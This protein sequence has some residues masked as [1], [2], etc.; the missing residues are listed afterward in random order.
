[1][2]CLYNVV[3]LLGLL[4]TLDKTHESAYIIL[5]ILYNLDE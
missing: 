5:K 1:M 2:F 3:V 4:L